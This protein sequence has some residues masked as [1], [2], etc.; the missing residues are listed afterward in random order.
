MCQYKYKVGGKMMRSKKFL[1]TTLAVA[2]TLTLAIPT[3]VSAKEQQIPLP[4]GRGQAISTLDL[5]S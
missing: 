4:T 3:Q 1:L 2:I 5:D